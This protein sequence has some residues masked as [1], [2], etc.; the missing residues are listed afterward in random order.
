MQIVRCAACDGYGWIADEDQGGTEVEC[1]WCGGIGYA[2]RG[3]DGIDRAIPTAEWG[4]YAADFERLERE[5]LREI[6]YTGDAKHPRDQAI[7]K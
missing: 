3:E 7:R 1:G 6:G 2:S 5:R 4:R